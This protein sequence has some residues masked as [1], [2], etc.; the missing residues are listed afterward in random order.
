MSKIIKSHKE[1]EFIEKMSDKEY[2][3]FDNLPNEY[4]TL[5]LQ[6]ISNRI[7]SYSK[8]RMTELYN[9]SAKKKI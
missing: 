9:H 8:D 3:F 6:I 2:D 5:F 1:F 4:K 7:D